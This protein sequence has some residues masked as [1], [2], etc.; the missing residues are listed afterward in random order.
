MPRR[1]AEQV[2]KSLTVLLSFKSLCCSACLCRE[3]RRFFLDDWGLKWLLHLNVT[4]PGMHFLCASCKSYTRIHSPADEAPIDADVM[5]FV[6][7]CQ[8]RP[9]EQ[10]RLAASV[11]MIK[12]RRCRVSRLIQLLVLV[13]LWFVTIACAGALS[14]HSMMRLRF[15]VLSIVC[16]SK[17]QAFARFQLGICEPCENR[18]FFAFR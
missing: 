16:V 18:A 14:V 2:R 15:N 11:A 12:L 4:S 6:T 1:S 3:L 9:G 8:A 10:S 13:S 5:D 7:L 17:V